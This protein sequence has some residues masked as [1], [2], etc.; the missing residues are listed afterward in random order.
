MTWSY[1]IFL[2]DLLYIFSAHTQFW[3][4]AHPLRAFKDGYIRQKMT[5][6]KYSLLIAQILMAVRAL[7]WHV[8]TWHIFYS[9][10][11]FCAQRRFWPQNHSSD[12]VLTCSAFALQG[13]HFSHFNRH[14]DSCIS[15]YIIFA[16][17]ISSFAFLC[18]IIFVFRQPWRVHFGLQD[19]IAHILL[20]KIDTT[21]CCTI[22]HSIHY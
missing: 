1:S 10:L 7:R 6:K 17:C 19:N 9:E 20:W 22:Q 12:R 8:E 21:V 4:S 13:A 11:C 5:G 3:R 2:W 14:C 15:V 18:D 16:V